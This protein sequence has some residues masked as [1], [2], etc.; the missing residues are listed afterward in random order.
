VTK[1]ERVD[2]GWRITLSQEARQ[3]DD[4]LSVQGHGAVRLPARD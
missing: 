1:K 4:E 3:Q 2:D